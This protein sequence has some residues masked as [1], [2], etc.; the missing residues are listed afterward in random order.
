VG[1]EQ[2]PQPGD[3]FALTGA[4]EPGEG[5]V[6]LQE[7]V[8][9]DVCWVHFA[10]ELATNLNAGQDGQ[11]TAARLQELPQGRAAARP[12]ETE[13][14]VRVW[15]VGGVHSWSALPDKVRKEVPVYRKKVPAAGQVLLGLLARMMHGP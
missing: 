1:S 15:H 5:T 2:L 13:K 6:R 3:E 7:Y 8:L 11:V 4:T 10:L 14:I 12:G 9:D